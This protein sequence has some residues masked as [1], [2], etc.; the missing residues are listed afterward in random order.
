MGLTHWLRRRPSD[1]EMR[2]ELEAHLA[3]RAEYDGVDEAAARRRLGNLMGTR[4][5]RSQL[6][7]VEALDPWSWT[8]ALLTLSVVLVVAVFRPA[9]RAAH[10]DP[11]TALR[12]E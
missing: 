5:L 10:V 4:A 11:V 9:H 7:Q 3:M 12:A 2:E 8:G 6:Y 1:D